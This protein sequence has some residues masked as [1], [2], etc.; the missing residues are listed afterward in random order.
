MNKI[1]RQLIDIA[2]QIQAMTNKQ[3]RELCNQLTKMLDGE[4]LTDKEML[5]FLKKAFSSNYKPLI[6][7]IIN[8]FY[9]Y[10]QKHI[11]LPQACRV[12]FLKLLYNYDKEQITQSLL[13]D[14][15]YTDLQVKKSGINVQKQFNYIYDQT[16]GWINQDD[17]RE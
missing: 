9:L 1:S 14:L 7:D 16:I 15:Q 3:I 10:N 13:N 11:Q 6:Q 17:Y 5:S 8:Q 2:K 12:T 4:L